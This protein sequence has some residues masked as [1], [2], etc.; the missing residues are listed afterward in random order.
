MRSALCRQGHPG[1]GW[2]LLPAWIPA[3]AGMTDRGPLPWC[4]MNYQM[5][6]MPTMDM[7]SARVSESSWNSPSMALVV[8]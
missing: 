4:A 1:E 3:F 7:N 8:A 6:F 5:V 2:G